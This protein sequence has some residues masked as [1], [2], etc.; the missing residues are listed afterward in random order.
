MRGLT[1]RWLGAF[2]A[3]PAVLLGLA[4]GNTQAQ[5]SVPDCVEVRAYVRWGASAYDHYVGLRSQC[6]RP[7]TC[8]V[9]TNV[10]PEPQ[11][12]V[13]PAGAAVDVMT[14]RGSPAREHTAR[15]ACELE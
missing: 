12:V 7:A 1:T 15:V 6:E 5:N 4:G 14:F 11:R 8:Q 2:L 9:A 3:V 10:N 13:L